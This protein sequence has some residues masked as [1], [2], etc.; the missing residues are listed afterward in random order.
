MSDAH[1]HVFT[2]NGFPYGT[3]HGKPVKESVYQPDWRTIERRDYTMLLADVLAQLLPDGV[4][5]TIST[6]PG[7][8]RAWIKSEQDT[9]QIAV[10]LAECAAHQ[11]A[12]YE[13]TGKEI[14]LCLEPEPDCIIETTEQTVAFFDQCV[15]GKTP[16][17]VASSEVMRRYVGVCLDTC[18]LSVQFE[19]LETGF[20][21][22]INHGIRVPKIQVSA[23]LELTD[24]SVASIQALTAYCDPVYL[25]QTKVLCRDGTI[26]SWPDLSEKTLENIGQTDAKRLRAHFHVPLYFEKNDPFSSTARDLTEGFFQA[27]LKHDP[28][29]LE[30]E[31]YTFDVLPQHMR[32]MPVE[33]SIEKEYRWV[34]QRL[35]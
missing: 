9:R 26:R 12:I 22:L 15:F 10:H 21:T 30:I 3:F 32:S 31:T 2:I 27:I 33:E 5:G 7:S 11:K 8:Y 28:M 6:V 35:L 25:H 16:E 13:R 14:C 24:F 17:E 1:L 23:G 29:H 20:A 18:H 4:T 19:D 34:L